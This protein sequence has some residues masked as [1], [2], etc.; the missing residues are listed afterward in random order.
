MNKEHTKRIYGIKLVLAA[1]MIC[2]TNTVTAAL[3]STATLT[4]TPAPGFISG[5]TPPA[6]GSWFSM[7]ISAGFFSFTPVESFSG[8]VIGTSQL[9]TGSHGGLPGGINTGEHPDVG[10][11]WDFFGQTGIHQTTSAVTILSDNGAG[12]VTLDLSGWDVTWNGL[13]SIP[14]DAAAWGTNADSVADVVCAVDCA[15]GDTFT[16]D[17]TATVPTPCG[18]GCGFSGVIVSWFSLCTV[19]YHCVES[20][21]V[22]ACT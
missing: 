19:L 3:D 14:M 4:Y 10:V 2:C 8:I 15:D 1:C 18:V 12:A 17:Y 21:S 22:V 6:T 9:A 13:A 11:P 5:P 20:V 16:L 7:T